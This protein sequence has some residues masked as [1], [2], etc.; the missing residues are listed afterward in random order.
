M[1][2]RT[3]NPVTGVYPA[4]PDYV[5]ALELRGS[6][7]LLF[8]SGTMG[9]DGG[10][11]AA[12]TLEAQL[13]LVWSNIRRILAEAG[14]T[15]DNIMRVTSYLRD[16]GYA[17][18]NQQA[19]LTALGRRRVPTTAIVVETLTPDWLVEIEVIAAA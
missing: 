7:R 18:K 10:G 4:T 15:T 3:V 14:M 8:V 13:D 1:E 11:Q 19:R 17:E 5:H 12:E 16:A 9:L 2:E 6:E